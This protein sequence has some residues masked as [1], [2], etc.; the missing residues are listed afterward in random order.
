MFVAQG[1]TQAAETV[2]AVVVLFA[3]VSV[4]FWRVLLRIVLTVAAIALLVLLTSGA[5]LIFEIIHR[6]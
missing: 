2:Q 3:A 5:M 1:A 6:R 4:I